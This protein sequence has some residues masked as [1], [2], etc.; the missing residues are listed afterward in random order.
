VFIIRALLEYNK[1]LNVQ[2][3]YYFDTFTRDNIIIRLTI[4][5][6]VNGKIKSL[7]I[8]D[9]LPIILGSLRDLSK[10]YDIENPKS[11]FPYEM[12]NED[13][14]WYK[15]VSPDKNF[16]K[17]DDRDI[18]EFN[19]FYKDNYSDKWSLEDET[20]KYLIL[21]LKSLHQILKIVNLQM[22]I[23]FDIQMTR[24]STISGIAVRVFLKHYY[25]N[26]FIPHINSTSIYN[27]L[28]KSYYG[29][30]VE[31]YIPRPVNGEKLYYYD[32]NSL[33]PFA[34]LNDLP[35]LSWTFEDYFKNPNIDDLFGF[36]YCEIECYDRYLGLLPVRTSF[37]S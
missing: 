27:D 11:F 14:L 7:S 23:N 25:D 10:S 22:F 2:D 9:S 29:G 4:K 3:K 28:Y 12:V 19:E 8:H 24:N 30:R 36:Y 37:I 13:Y 33:Y 6:R 5:R 1:T 35:G 15:G 26:K 18:I 16:Y 20:I 21:D 34:S 32:V 17:V 31:V